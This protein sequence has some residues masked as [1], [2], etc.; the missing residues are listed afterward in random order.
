M[1]K[2]IAY[3]LLLSMLSTMILST[4]ITSNAWVSD[5]KYVWP[6]ATTY[7]ITSGWTSSHGGIDFGVPQG[8]SVQAIASGTVVT[9]TD[10][11]CQGSHKPGHVTCPLGTSCA[12]YIANPDDGS[13]ANWII[14]DHGNNVYSLYAHL[15]TGSFAVSR[16]QTVQQG[17]VI[18]ASGNAG[19]STGPHLH[20][21]LR[22][23]ANRFSNTVNPQSYLTMTNVSSPSSP[24]IPEVQPT[25]DVIINIDYPNGNYSLDN[26]I[27]IAG[28]VVS[29][30]TPITYVMCEVVGVDQYVLSL[31]DAPDV[32]NE[33]QGYAY[34]K[35]FRGAI[36]KDLL[37]ANTSYTFKVWAG[38]GQAQSEVKSIVFNTGDSSSN[39]PSTSME[40]TFNIDYPS[41]KYSGSNNIEVAGWIASTDII[42]YSMGEVV[43]VYQ[44]DFSLEDY[45]ELASVFPGSSY[46]YFKKFRGVIEIA[47][48]TSNTEYT[49]RVWAGLGESNIQT[50]PSTKKFSTGELTVGKYNIEFDANGGSDVPETI[51]V[52]KGTS[53][54]IPLAMPSREGYIFLGWSTDKDATAVEYYIGSELIPSSDMVLYAVWQE[55]H[56]HDYILS[57]SKDASCTGTGELVYTCSCGDSYTEEIPALGH[58]PGTAV[59]IKAPTC[60][61]EGINTT[62]CSVCEEIISTETTPTVDHNWSEWIQISAPTATEDGEQLRYCKTCKT[63]ETEVIPA[64]GEEE[65]DPEPEEPVDPNAPAVISVN[66]YT[67]SLDKI[68][69]IK[70]IRFAIGHYTKGTDIKAAEKNVTLD[71]STV[72]KYTVDGVFTY[73]LPWMGEYTFWV[74]YNDGSQYFIYTN[75]DDITPY[76][77]SYGVKITVKDYAEDYKDMWLAEGTFNSYNEI[78]A[79][80]AF[81]YQASANKLD[82]YA[83]TTHDFSYTMTNPGPYTVLI[84]YND[85]SVDVIHTTLTVDVPEFS[86]NG[87]QV[88]VTN[89][90]DIKIIRTAYGHYTS[91]GDIKKASGVRNFSNKTD[92]KNA[93]SYMIQ[94]RDSGEVTMIV[95]YNNGYKHFYYLDIQPKSATMIQSKN[96]VMFD[97][98]D[99]FVMIRY[100]KGVYTTSSQIKAAAGSKVLKPADLISGYAIISGLEKGTYTFCVQFDDESYDYYTVTV[101]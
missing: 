80:T 49:F 29:K 94:Y 30:S 32:S 21:E 83:K 95:E 92:I 47:R 69:D 66:N 44:M 76:V 46:K 10:R 71:A 28:W 4:A 62:Y 68:T 61:E 45:P 65:P 90:P 34:A 93:D 36:N 38:I 72:A 56:S 78:K 22:I 67:V 98:L 11:G 100:A 31:E 99:G 77:E 48:L 2:L 87:L 17:Q 6:V 26:N 84:R 5:G 97:D 57:A 70:E 60:T 1:K 63:S 37:S 35:R 27:E 18:A 79:S 33:Y 7:P 81:K 51:M 101:A 15:K 39:Q 96:T 23:G 91:V 53:L 12:A 40:Y 42:Q 59:E 82:L 24:S 52:N 85:G 89:I 73:D 55:N 50:N 41:G 3:L 20:L 8:T 75:V 13:Y 43:G 88:T 58:T 64:T 74:R 86:A 14:I 25:Q 54:A 9:A 16:G 19:N